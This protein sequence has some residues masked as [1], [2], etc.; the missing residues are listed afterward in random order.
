MYRGSVFSEWTLASN[1]VLLGELLCSA[2]YKVVQHLMHSHNSALD[3]FVDLCCRGTICTCWMFGL[4]P[5]QALEV[6]HNL[7]FLSALLPHYPPWLCTLLADIPCWHKT[8]VCPAFSCNGYKLCMCAAFLLVEYLSAH[9]NKSSFLWINADFSLLSFIFEGN[10]CIILLAWLSS[11]C[12]EQ[13]FPFVCHF[14]ALNMEVSV[15]R[16][17]VSLSPVLS[18]SF[19]GCPCVLRFYCIFVQWCVDH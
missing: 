5:Y 12:G 8:I 9:L 15:V 2:Y 11:L 16:C 18:W 7:I 3:I 10:F 13:I 19:A 17:F 14:S 4:P 6:I 1:F